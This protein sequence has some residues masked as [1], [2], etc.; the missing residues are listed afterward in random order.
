MYRTKYSQ[1][2][3]RHRQEW[4]LIQWALCSGVVF[5]LCYALTT[6][7]HA[8][9]R[10]AVRLNTTARAGD[11]IQLSFDLTS[12]SSVTNELRILDFTHDGKIRPIASSGLDYSE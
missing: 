6:E 8:M 9:T 10:Y 1:V 7:L 3:A 5:S 2:R 12:D 11:K 4:S